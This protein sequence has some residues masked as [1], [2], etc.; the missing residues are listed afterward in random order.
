MDRS[1]KSAVTRLLL[2]VYLLLLAVAAHAAPKSTNP[3][4][5]PP[6]EIAAPETDRLI[7]NLPKSYGPWLADLFYVRYD[8]LEAAGELLIGRYAL[9]KAQACKAKIR[10]TY[11]YRKRWLSPGEGSLCPDGALVLYYRYDY[12]P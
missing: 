8:T 6:G 4:P 10:K 11:T 12:K 2:L 9:T 5:P 3:R 1:L 7:E